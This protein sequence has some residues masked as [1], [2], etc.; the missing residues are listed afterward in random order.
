MSFVIANAVKQS[1]E[2]KK[3]SLSFIS[4]KLTDW[5]N[6]TPIRCTR[7]DRIQNLTT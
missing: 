4:R 3:K 5:F 1:V 7:N 2:M 6:E